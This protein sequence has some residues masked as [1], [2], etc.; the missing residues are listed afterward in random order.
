MCSEYP[1]YMYPVLA[2]SLLKVHYATAR[3][4][5]VANFWHFQSERRFSRLRFHPRTILA[6]V[7]RLLVRVP[8]GSM[9]TSGTG[10]ETRS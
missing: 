5:L 10:A 3:D 6:C 9:R 8:E 2:L 7:E 1:I 4:R